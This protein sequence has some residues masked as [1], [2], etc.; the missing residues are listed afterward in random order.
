MRHNTCLA[1]AVFAALVL[2]ALLVL[3]VLPAVLPSLREPFVS[4]EAV[5][6]SAQARELFA[7]R[8]VTDYSAYKRAVPSA[9]PVTYSVAR[10]LWRQKQLTPQ[11][12]QAS[13]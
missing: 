10:A 5:E 4:R 13:L 11:A 6:I 2:L 9:D 12:V 3:L 8:G 7:Q 1:I